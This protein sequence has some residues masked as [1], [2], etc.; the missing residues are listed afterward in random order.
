MIEVG[1]V[2]VLFSFVAKVVPYSRSMEAI[3]CCSKTD[4]NV[5]WTGANTFTS[6]IRPLPYTYVL[7]LAAVQ[8]MFLI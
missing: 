7:S 6:E 8:Y 1:T 3:E 5:Q 4:M 2:K